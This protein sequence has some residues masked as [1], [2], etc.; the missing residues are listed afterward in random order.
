LEAKKYV[1]LERIRDGKT[2]ADF[3]G[4]EGQIVLSKRSGKKSLKE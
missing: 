2:S 3:G 1:Y 4:E